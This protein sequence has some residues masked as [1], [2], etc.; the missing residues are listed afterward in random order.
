MLDLVPTPCLHLT[1]TFRKFQCVGKGTDSLLLGVSFEIQVLRGPV[2]LWGCET[3]TLLLV[4]PS[5][6]KYKEIHG[7]GERGMGTQ[8]GTGY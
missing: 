3:L 6:T 2:P 5:G 8:L 7:F 4:C 1:S